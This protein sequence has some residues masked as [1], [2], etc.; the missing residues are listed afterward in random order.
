MVVDLRDRIFRRPTA[1]HPGASSDPPT[2]NN[3]SPASAAA[4]ANWHYTLRTL[5]LSRPGWARDIPTGRGPTLVL[6]EGHFMYLAPATVGRVVREVVDYFGKGQLAFDK[7]GTLAVRL[8]GLA[9][10]QRFFRASRQAAFT[11]AVDDPREV[12]ALV[13]PAGRLRLKDCVDKKTF[14]VCDLTLSNPLKSPV[15]VVDWHRPE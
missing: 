14:M 6:A 10:V 3:N 9:R 15:T 4:S 7:L 5:D 2:T 8:Q 1:V 11:W 13:H 12:E